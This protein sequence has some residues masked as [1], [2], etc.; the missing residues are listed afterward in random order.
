M[1]HIVIIGAGIGG[2]PMAYEMRDAARAVGR[3]DDIGMLT[4]GRIADLVVLA[5]DPAK[6]A[7][8]WRSLS[9]VSRAGVLRER[10]TLR[11]R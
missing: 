10:D 2:L 7:K 11:F 8:A 4:A 1:A 9:H 5:E 3:G 6:D